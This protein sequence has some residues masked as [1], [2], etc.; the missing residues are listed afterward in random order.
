MYRLSSNCALNASQN[1]MRYRLCWML[2]L[3]KCPSN[4][5]IFNNSWVIKK[6]ALF[7]IVSQSSNMKL[8]KDS[9]VVLHL[10]IYFWYLQKICSLQNCQYYICLFVSNHRV[11]ILLRGMHV[12]KCAERMIEGSDISW[13]GIERNVRVNVCSTFRVICAV[14]C[15]YPSVP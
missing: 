8:M 7:K 15:F 12:I 5:C 1:A 6:K 3:G 2:H 4:S 11:I 9:L 10:Q 13:K 14:L